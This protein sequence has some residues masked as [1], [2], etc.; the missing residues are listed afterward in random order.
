MIVSVC[1]YQV[2]FGECRCLTSCVLAIAYCCLHSNLNSLAL[3]ARDTTLR[4]GRLV[5]FPRT[6]V[7]MSV[8]LFVCAAKGSGIGSYR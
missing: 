6:D 4:A 1:T 5:Y 3:T 7:L 8:W 2:D